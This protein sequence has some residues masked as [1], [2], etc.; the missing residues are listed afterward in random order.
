MNPNP[1]SPSM[2]LTPKLYQ[3]RTRR[4][5][6]V[7]TDPQRRCYNGAYFSVRYDWSEWEVLQS[8]VPEHDCA[9]VLTFWRELNDYAVSARGE[10][11]RGEYEMVA[12]EAEHA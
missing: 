7:N 12:Q 5:V 10:E 11:A 3:L 6:M 8:N 4:R 1:W 2:N 9:R